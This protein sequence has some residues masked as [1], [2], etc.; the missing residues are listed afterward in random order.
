MGLFDF[1]KKNKNENAEKDDFDILSGSGMIEYIRSNLKNP[2]PENVLKVLENVAKP[3]DDLERL[4]ED[5]E[6]PW[7]WHSHNKD[8]T[9]KINGEYS[10]FLD[11]WLDARK[12]SPKE[13]YSA[14]RW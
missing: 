9:G 4:T 14:L 8:F 11:K 12:K 13:L 3:D 10:Y 1:L 6:L 5:G 2:S 7:G